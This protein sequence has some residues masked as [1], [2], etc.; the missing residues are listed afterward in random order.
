M[1]PL[2]LALIFALQ[3]RDAVTAGE[4]R[5]E[6]P[7][8]LCLGFEWTIEGDDHRSGKPQFVWNVNDD[9]TGAA[10]DLGALES[11]RPVPV[12]GPRP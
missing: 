12:Y 5:A 10:P 3:S 11:G 2:T 7:T 1:N 8:L 6:P 9:A 4:F